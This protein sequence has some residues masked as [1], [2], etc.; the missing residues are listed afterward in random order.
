MIPGTKQIKIIKA[1]E[2]TGTAGVHLT[3]CITANKPKTIISITITTITTTGIAIGK[4]TA[5]I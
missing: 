2:T 5:G 3:V 1:V 4:G